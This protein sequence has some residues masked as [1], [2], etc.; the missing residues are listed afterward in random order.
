MPPE[1]WQI[2]EAD[3]ARYEGWYETARGRR[4]EGAEQA[5]LGWLLRRFPGASTAVEVGCGTGRFTRALERR[6]LSTIGLDRSPAMLSELRRHASRTPVVLADAHALPLASG[7]VD[8]AVF[9]TTLEFLEDPQRALAEAVRVARRGVIALVL[10][11]WSVGGLSR[12]WGRASRGA[13]LRHARDVSLPGARRML[14]AAAGPRL[15]A[16]WWRSA[17]LPP[18]LSRLAGLLPALPVGDVLGLAVELAQGS[19]RD[20]QSGIRSP[21]RAA[22]EYP[23]HANPSDPRRAT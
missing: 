16:A 3:P 5:L 21:S 7:A 15:R 18:P 4:A 20:P 6:G 1:M 17:L 19:R 10:N 23:R 9:V 14:A 13:L 11:R 22:F 8:L 12:R 2:F